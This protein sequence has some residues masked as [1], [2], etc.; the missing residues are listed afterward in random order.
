MLG[1]LPTSIAEMR[2][3]GPP[4]T[5]VPGA[6]NQRGVA[7]ALHAWLAPRLDALGRCRSGD[8]CPSCR[9]G[10]PCALDTWRGSLAPSTIAQT[11]TQVVAFWNTTASG[12][13][14]AHGGGR[15]YLAMRRSAPELAD[16]ALRVCLE[17]HRA[18]HD[19]LTAALLAEQ[20][21]RTA[22]CSDPAVTEVRVRTIAAGGRPADLAAALRVCHAVLCRRAGSTDPAWASL[23]TRTAQL[24][25]RDRRQRA[26][27]AGRHAPR[28]LPRPP[29]RARFL[30]AG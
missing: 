7:L 6:G 20:V 16:A 25:A 12:A 9:E 13:T 21:W 15:G 23:E 8:P 22:A 5:R 11:E 29:R 24:A 27:A 26:A 19:R 14:T 2:R 10:E 17:F 3:H 28:L 30:R 1:R 18:R 4:L